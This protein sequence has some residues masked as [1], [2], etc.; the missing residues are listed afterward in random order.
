MQFCLNYMYVKSGGSSVTL[1]K[2]LFLP[3]TL[4]PSLWDPW[5]T[6]TV[7]CWLLWLLAPA[8]HKEKKRSCLFPV[9]SPGPSTVT[10]AKQE[11]GKE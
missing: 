1:G 5:H 7:V 11:L 3:S 10:D 4:V 2:I 8:C 6:D 9:V